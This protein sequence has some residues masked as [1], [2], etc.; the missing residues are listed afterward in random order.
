[1]PPREALQAIGILTGNA[2]IWRG[3]LLIAVRR[4]FTEPN[5]LGE[6]VTITDWIPSEYVEL[7]QNSSR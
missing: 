5:R 4:I 1:M 6:H 3:R 2:K 7:V